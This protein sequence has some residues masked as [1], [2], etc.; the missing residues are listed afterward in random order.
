[1]EEMLKNR[2]GGYVDTDL[3]PVLQQNEE[4]FAKYYA[5]EKEHD[6]GHRPGF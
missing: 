3:L 4:M 2:S 1:M 5:T 6:G